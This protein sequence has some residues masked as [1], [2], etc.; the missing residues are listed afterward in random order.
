VNNEKHIA[1]IELH[2]DRRLV[3]ARRIISIDHGV[4]IVRIESKG[5]D[6]TWFVSAHNVGIPNAA[7]YLLHDAIGRAAEMARLDRR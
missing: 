3:V 5:H 1:T 7:L 6:G 2:P 4:T